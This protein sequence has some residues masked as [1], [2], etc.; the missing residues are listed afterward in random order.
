MIESLLVF[1]L[2]NGFYS[3]AAIFTSSVISRTEDEAIKLFA[4]RSFCQRLLPFYVVGDPLCATSCSAAIASLGSNR[5]YGKGRSV[6][7]CS[8]S[9]Y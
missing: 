4:S 8:L 3:D 5:L 6:T 9:T 1:F 2:F 7:L